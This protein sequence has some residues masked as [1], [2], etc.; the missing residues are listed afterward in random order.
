MRLGLLIGTLALALGLAIA[1][2]Q[3][4]A[5]VGRQAA[6]S[7][8]SAERAMDDVRLI[9]RAPHPAG[10]AEHAAVRERLLARMTALGLSPQVQTGALDPR[11]IQAMRER[12]V[13]QPPAVAQNLIGV[14][15]GADPAAP[16]VVMMAHYDSAV[17]SP[18]A[19]DDATGVAAILEG[20]RAIKARGAAKRDLIVLI[21][22]A[23]EI[24]LDGAR[25]FFNEHPLRTRVGM[26]VNLEARGGGGRAAMFETGRGN[27]ETIAVYERASRRATGGPDS[28]SLAIFVYENMPNGTDYTIPKEQGTPGLNFAFIGRPSQYHSATSTPE[29]LD[30]GS[31]QHIGSQ[32]LEATDA[33]LRAPALPTAT[34]DRV[35]ADVFGQFIIGHAPAFGWTLLGIAAVLWLFAAWGARHASGLTFADLGGGILGGIWTITTAVV[36]TGL[37][38]VLAGPMGQRA[39]SMESYYLMMRRLPWLEAGVALMVTSI[40]LT[41]IIGRDLIGRRV[42]AGVIV[43][44][45]GVVLL[46][47]GVDVVMIGA[48]V[49]AASLSLWPKADARPPW[50]GWL[51]LILLVMVLAALAQAFAPQAAFLF[52]WPVLVASGTAA[53][54]ALIGAKLERWPSLVPPVVAGVVMGGWLMG[55]SHGVFLGVGATVPAVTVLLALLIML[56][57]RPLQPVGMGGRSVAGLAAAC[58]VIACAMA[59]TGVVLEPSAP[60]AGARPMQ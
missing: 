43:L 51:G 28:N 2:L 22:D 23:E 12:G 19:A 9:A 11:V 8:F 13:A 5:P 10:S 41:A 26:V 18:G 6:A 34:V 42:L 7:D 37:V 36:L 45:A 25:I 30:Q 46:V 3:T 21:T 47:G 15:P 55:W 33:L 44:S 60:P 50:G 20:V 40:A 4:P 32:A 31:L 35:Y 54:S 52:V 24:G 1:T 53:V 29:A 39:G 58:A 17:G 14:L 49:I 38:R 59:L 27:A 57:V 48:A 56:F 16:A